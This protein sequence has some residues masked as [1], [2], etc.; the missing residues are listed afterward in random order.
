[1]SHNEASTQDTNYL[2]DKFAL[3]FFFFYL[4]KMLISQEINKNLQLKFNIFGNNF[5]LFIIISL[6][7][8]IHIVIKN[9]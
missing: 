8:A 1:M 5:F 3:F 9:Y 6:T 2:S 4:Q 7:I